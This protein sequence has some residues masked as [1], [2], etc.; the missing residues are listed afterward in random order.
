MPRIIIVDDHPLFR[1]GLGYALKSLGFEVVGEAS[2]GIEGVRRVTELKPDAVLLD[3]KMPRMD[4]LEACREIIRVLPRTRVIMLTTFNEPA[5]IQA[6][7]DAGAAGFVNKET[8]AERLAELLRKMLEDD[9]YTRFPT[10]DLP[11]LSPRELEVLRLM[12][13]GQSNKEIA[14]TLG[15]SPDTI[16]DHLEN[17]YR[18][19]E[20][21]DRVTA[22]KRA[23]QLG[24]V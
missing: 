21:S 4:G 17:L 13:S 23:Q 11:K 2:D 15:L 1:I 8:E 22:A 7:K 3:A 14:R 24:L 6:A 5:L 20:A 9:H 12:A 18:K 16:K 10:I 19:L